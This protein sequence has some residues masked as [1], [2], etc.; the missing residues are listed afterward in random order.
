MTDQLTDRWIATWTAMRQ[1]RSTELAGWPLVH[2]GSVTRRTE[3]ICVDPGVE[4]F[5]SLL[6]HVA[7]DSEAMLT[8]V[9]HDLS[10]HRAMALPRDVRVD[11]DDET[12][13]TTAVTAVPVPE[14]PADLVATW[15]IAPGLVHYRVED[16]ARVVSEAAMG[17]H[18]QWV[19]FD[20]VETARS[21][22]R[23]GLGRHV[24]LA[25]LARAHAHGARHGVLAASADGRGLYEALGWSV[26]RELLSLMGAA[27]PAIR[28]ATSR[29]R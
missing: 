9:G 15:E 29:S 7:G 20:S 1:L 11:R 10:A 18:D 12:L 17:L 4:A 16:G 27:A 8:V 21:H 28:T 24:M 23:R 19:T 2:V 22:Q 14:L 5:R 13:M 3:L 6:P 26:Q 25:L